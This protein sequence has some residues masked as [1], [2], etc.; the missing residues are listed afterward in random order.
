MP[1]QTSGSKTTTGSVTL[2]KPQAEGLVGCALSGDYTGLSFV[3][4][5]SYDGNNWFPV[6]AQSAADASVVSGTVSPSD[7]SANAWKVPAEFLASVR[8]RVTAVSANTATFV[9]ASGV[10][11]APSVSTVC[12]TGQTVAG[13]V[14]STS[15]TSGVGYGAG[16]GG[17]V[18]QATS[19]TTG[20]TLNKVSGAITLFSA[21]GSATPATFTLTNSA[22]AAADT[23]SVAQKSG[24]DLYE[25]FVTNVAA[26]SC[27]V[28]FFTTGGT[29]TEQPVFNFNVVKGSAS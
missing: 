10:F 23:V 13:P 19:R 4:E 2:T 17:A 22:I 29:T 15:A 6:A 11:S 18:T 14:L 8:A 1:F 25:I 7:A 26:G 28:T 3:F 21:A 24:T 20:V 27:K 5:G 16:A 9:L 12:Q